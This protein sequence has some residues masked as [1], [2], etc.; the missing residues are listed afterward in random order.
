MSLDDRLGKI[1]LIATGIVACAL[2]GCAIA[3][4]LREER[5]EAWEYC[6]GTMYVGCE[7]DIVLVK[8]PDFAVVYHMDTFNGK[9]TLKELNTCGDKIHPGNITLFYDEET[10]TASRCSCLETSQSGGARLDNYCLLDRDEDGEYIAT[11]ESSHDVEQAE[12]GDKSVMINGR[13]YP[14]RE[15]SQTESGETLMNVVDQGGCVTAMDIYEASHEGSP[16]NV[17]LT[18]IDGRDL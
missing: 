8:L 18:C 4:P 12:S 9:T 11:P 13:L 2:S 6:E 17:E 16:L 1:K 5:T 14:I 7:L 15:G 3:E 10:T